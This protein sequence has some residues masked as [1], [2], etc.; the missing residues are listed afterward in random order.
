MSYVDRLRAEIA[1][2]C[3]QLLTEGKPLHASWI[4]HEVCNLHTGG[5]AE[6]DDADFWRH[7]GYHTTRE[8]TRRYISK[9]LGASAERAEARQGTFPGFRHVQ[10]HYLVRRDGDDTGVPALEMTDQEIEAKAEEYEA[11]GEACLAHAEELRRFKLWRVSPAVAA[12]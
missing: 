12:Q 9:R 3:E 6:N 11:M 2:K 5:L 7:G 10:S 4:T 1:A 8:E